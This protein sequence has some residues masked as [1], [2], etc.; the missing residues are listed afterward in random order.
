MFVDTFYRY[1]IAATCFGG[2]FFGI[3]FV[4]QCGGPLLMCGTPAAPT[5]RRLLNNRTE[6]PMFTLTLFTIFTRK[7]ASRVIANALSITV[8]RVVLAR[9][10]DVID[11]VYEKI[12][13]HGK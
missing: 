7:H 2:M 4:A 8:L 9:R 5:T 6:S 3:A 12:R 11:V 13:G 10:D 1:T